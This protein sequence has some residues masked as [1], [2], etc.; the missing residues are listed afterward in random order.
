MKILI[1]GDFCDY[2]RVSDK[3]EKGEYDK[4]FSS[5]KPII[6]N[7]D[8]SIVNF[9]FPIVMRKAKP[10]EKTGANLKG[11]P[12]SVNA[13]KYA[14][15]KAATMANNHILD[16]GPDCLL[17]TINEL[18][19]NG[20]EPIGWKNPNTSYSEINYFSTCK[21]NI[22]I[23]NCCEREFSIAKDNI[24]GAIPLNPIN[25]WY[26]IKEA[27]EKA[28]T[29]I[30]IVHGGIEHYQFPTPRMKETYR[31]FI[32]A[33][34]D[35][36]VNHHQHCFSGYEE[37][38]G[39]PIFYGLGN[40]L[41]D[42]KGLYDT[43]W[44]NGYMVCFNIEDNKVTFELYPYKQCGKE[45]TVD[46]I[47]DRKEFYKELNEINEKISDDKLLERYMH[48]YVK[49]TEREFK[50]AFSPYSNRYLN[51]LYIRGFLPDFR[52]QKSWLIIQNLI[53]CES[54]RERLL[55]YIDDKINTYIK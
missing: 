12:K 48:E 14:G 38:H 51:A 54:H 21:G 26:K 55:Q 2:G 6:E 37:Y 10:I 34:A 46:L 42:R 43:I 53:R 44:N 27:K 49:K 50:T 28:D 18:K 11:T 4:L 23:I 15:F 52:S 16:W 3:I 5:V 20:I 41:F 19:S 33:G 8:L 29:V 25:Q 22:A 47:E 17:D 1:A 24:P 9:E 35:V 45:P 32:D 30:V 36:V 13:I 31:F 39:K 7:A 40:F